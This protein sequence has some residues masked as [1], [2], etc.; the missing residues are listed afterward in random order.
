MDLLGWLSLAGIC[1]LGAMSPGPSLL[2]VMR[3]SASGLQQGLASA[4]AHGA[5]VAVYAALTAFGLAVLITSSPLLFSILQWGGAAMLVYLGWKAFRAPAPG[6]GTTQLEAPHLSVRRSILQ[7][8]GVAFFNPKI[9][10]FFT[11]LFSQFVSEQQALTTKLGMAAMVSGVDTLWYC[12]VALA[13]HASRKRQLV[14]KHL[15]HRIQQLFGLLLIG[16]AA[17]LVL[18]I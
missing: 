16:L 12:I 11:A 7:G 14:S 2:I 9:A 18:T 13:V 15:G 1:A 17:R 6:S 3:C 4:I 10:V 5:G 8:F